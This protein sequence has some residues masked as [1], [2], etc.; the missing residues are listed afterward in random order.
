MMRMKFSFRAF[1]VAVCCTLTWFCTEAGAQV[2]NP[3]GVAVIVGN[4]DYEHR[5]IPDVSFAHRDADAFR[6]YAVDVLGYDP[7]NI[8]DLRDATRGR[9]FFAYLR[10]QGRMR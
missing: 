5:D 7:E 9:S 8:I 6:R 1:L 10:A 4:K 3:K 2:R